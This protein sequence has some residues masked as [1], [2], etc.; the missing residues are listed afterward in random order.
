MEALSSEVDAM[1]SAV[2]E[3]KAATAAPTL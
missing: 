2:A 3:L 1:A